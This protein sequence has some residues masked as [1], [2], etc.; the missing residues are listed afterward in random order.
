MRSQFSTDHYQHFLFHVTDPWMFWYFVR[1][2]SGQCQCAAPE[3]NVVVVIVN[4]NSFDLTDQDGD[5]V[6][7]TALFTDIVI[8][9]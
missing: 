9:T 6:D 1:D 5:I 2:R 8:V 3:Q 4:Q 7:W